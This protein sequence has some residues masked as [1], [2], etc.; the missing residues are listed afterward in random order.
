MP[1]QQLRK[2]P[3][4]P[5]PGIIRL[6]QHELE[7]LLE[8]LEEQGYLSRYVALIDPTKIRGLFTAFPLIQL[9]DHGEDTFLAFQQVVHS[10]SEVMECFHV[11]GQYDFML[12]IVVGDAQLYNEFLRKNISTLPYVKKVESF[13]MLSEIKRETRYFI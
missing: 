11:M 3:E 1:F 2:H 6:R 9:A 4:Q 12:K 13:P 10:H 8:S 5:L 7:L